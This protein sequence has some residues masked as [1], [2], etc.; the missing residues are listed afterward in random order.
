LSDV[1]E[2]ASLIHQSKSLS[3]ELNEKMSSLSMKQDKQWQ[4]LADEA[5]DH[6]VQ[7]ETEV[8]QIVQV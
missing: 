3:D 6:I 8:K 1:T 2:L 7:L 4:S 5:G